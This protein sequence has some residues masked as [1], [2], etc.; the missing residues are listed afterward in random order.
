MIND[1]NEENTAIIAQGGDP[2]LIRMIGSGHSWSPQFSNDI[3]IGLDYFNDTYININVTS[4]NETELES[5]TPYVIVGAGA[6]IA[7]IEDALFELGYVLWG[8][9][10]AQ[11]Q[12]MGGMMG[13]GVGNTF[14]YMG[15]YCTDY[16][17]VDGNGIDRHISKDE[18]QTLLQAARVNGKYTYYT[19]ECRIVKKLSICDPSQK[20]KIILNLNCGCISNLWVWLNRKTV[21]NQ[22]QN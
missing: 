18:N 8:F 2:K 21:I 20:P 16:W 15:Q 10:A 19:H 13:H 5:E 22:I 3:M 9:G 17:L 12:T 6:I 11:F 4:L 7:D 1:V 14:G